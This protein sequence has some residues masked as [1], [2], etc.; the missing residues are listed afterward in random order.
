[1]ES[2][3]S[4]SVIIPVYNHVNWL[5]N[6]VQS[7]LNQTF[8][9]YEIIIIDD[10]STE[11]FSKF[12]KQYG[13]CI[14]YFRNENH[15]VAYSRNYGIKKARGKYIAFLDSDDY[16]NRNKLET[17]YFCMEENNSV[18][19]QHS[20]E[21]FYDDSKKRKKIDTNRYKGDILKYLFTSCMVQTS[22]FMV[23]KAEIQQYDI[24]FDEQ[25]KYGE[26]NVFYIELAKRYSITSIDE[27]LGNFRIHGTNA[28]KNAIIQI[29]A[30]KDIFNMY[31]RE[32]FFM[33]NTNRWVRLGYRICQRLSIIFPANYK[34]KLLPKCFYIFPWL[35]FKISSRG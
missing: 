21:Y 27:Y 24:K 20:Y 29:Q 10:G 26:D 30:R 31:G 12:L 14:R 18:W 15:G 2:N 11:D 22:C 9:D 19:S 3:P 13:S 32:D 17:Q 28:G 8:K 1:M 23:R 7:V 6:A 16:W 25:K 33:K 4:I 34:A 35:I 5:E